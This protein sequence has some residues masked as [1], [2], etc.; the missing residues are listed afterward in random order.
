MWV[1]DFTLLEANRLFDNFN[2]LDSDTNA[3]R[4][5][6][7]RI[8]RDYGTRPQELAIIAHAGEIRYRHELDSIDEI[9]ENQVDRLEHVTGDVKSNITE[10][11]QLM[12]KSENHSF[13][14]HS[15]P[16]NSIFKN[17]ENSASWLKKFHVVMLRYPSSKY[18]FDC[19]AIERAVLRRLNA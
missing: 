4:L 8:F 11:L 5:E 7:G 19:K 1:D 15:L 16:S 17:E 14:K 12:I 13:V 9:A 6:R 18:V 10:L 2:F 3:T